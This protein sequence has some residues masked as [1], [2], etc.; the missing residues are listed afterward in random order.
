M[1]NSN[2]NISGV[3]ISGTFSGDGS[4]LTGLP[5]GM[6]GTSGTSGLAGIS[7]TSGITGTSGTSGA[8]GANGSSGTSGISGSSGT[9]S[10]G[11]SGSGNSLITLPIYAYAANGVDAMW[12]P[13]V[14]TAG[15]TTTT[16]SYTANRLSLHYFQL[17]DGVTMTD[18]RARTAG[19]TAN[20]TLSIGI[21]SFSTYVTGGITYSLPSTLRYTVSTN[22]SLATTGAKT[23]SSLSYKFNS[24]DTVDNL[25]AI[26]YVPTANFTN[27]IFANGNNGSVALPLITCLESGGTLYRTQGWTNLDIGTSSLPTSCTA[28]LFASVNANT[29]ATYTFLKLIK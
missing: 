22:I 4:G 13:L 17:P 25:W 11:G 20:G 23:V 3:I 24:N 21:Y 1:I 18:L 27:V 16:S 2:N 29:E 14:Y 9:S 26:G 7:G 28:S 19:A 8:V 6:N 5:S 12:R 10:G 15:F